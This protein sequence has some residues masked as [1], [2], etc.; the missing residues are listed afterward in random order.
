VELERVVEMPGLYECIFKGRRVVA[1]ALFLFSAFGVS[2]QAFANT[3]VYN[4]QGGTSLNATFDNQAS[5]VR[6]EIGSNVV[7][8]LNQ[9]VS[10]SGMRYTGGGYEAYGKAGWLNVIRPGQPELRCQ[11]IG[12]I[13]TPV[14]SPPPQQ[15]TPPQQVASPSFNCGGRLNAT[16]ARL[17]ANPTLANLDRKMASTYSWLLGQVH[18]SQRGQLKQDQRQWL[19]TR[20]RCGSN[21]QCIE[22]VLYDR[23]GYLNE[24]QQPGQPPAPP[25][26]GGV[27]FPF[28]A[29]SWGGIVRS[30]PGT[31]YGKIASLREREPITVLQQTG[32]YY[33]DRPWFKI[34]FRGRTG[35][36]WGGI[37][38]PTFRP[39]P[40]TYQVCN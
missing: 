22:G 9:A 2:S 38:C 20:N 23:I 4:C 40:G 35:Y 36:H 16:E 15:F 32:Q 10:G 1:T 34:R 31:Q 37:I 12:Q 30:G 18:N 28:Q 29:K 8:T 17:C 3:T 27:S 11:Q 19:G 21:D 14:T 13:G 39:V 6:L 7:I 25:Q 33:Q 26:T 5:T 24:Y